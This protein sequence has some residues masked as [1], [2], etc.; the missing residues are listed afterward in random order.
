M[1]APKIKIIFLGTPHFAIPALR[2]LTQE[3]FSVVAVVTKPDEPA[4]REQILT[5]PPV[6]EAAIEYNIPVFQPNTLS[7]D[8]WIAN[9]PQADCF[10]VAAYGKL[11][12][13]TIIA[14]P[15]F[16]TL[17]VHPSLLPRLRGP[18]PIQYAILQGEKETGISIMLIDELMDHGPILAQKNIS[19]KDKK[20]GY[21][22]LHDILA[23][24]GAKLLMVSLPEWLAGIKKPIPQDDNH[25]TY[26]KILKKDDGRINWTRPAEEIERM[27][28]AFEVWPGSWTLWPTNKQIYRIRIENADE[29]PEE[30]PYGSPGYV[31]KAGNKAFPLVK[32]GR[33]SIVIK[34]LTMGG[35]K[36][37]DAREFLRG[38]PQFMGTTLI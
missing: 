33:G 2:A 35:K 8:Y 7:Y 29:S 15:R 20:M 6:K 4:G 31:W 22:E 9:L 30:S 25:A 24:E 16:G 28:R 18:S 36:A 38:Y 5:P 19:L 26:S 21:K 10:V 12:P 1:E 13:K 32:T 27:V 17:N 11:I 23:E 37:I 34:K 3:Y 14:L